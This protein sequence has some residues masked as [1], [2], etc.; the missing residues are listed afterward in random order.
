MSA[1][2]SLVLRAKNATTLAPVVYTSGSNFFSSEPYQVINIHTRDFTRVSP[3]QPITA[4]GKHVI[5]ERDKDHDYFDIDEVEVN[6]AAAT[7]TI[8]TQQYVD[9]AGYLVVN[10]PRYKLTNNQLNSVVVP[11]QWRRIKDLY[12]IQC[13]EEQY[14]RK[15]QNYL[16]DQSVAYLQ[17][18]FANGFRF[19][20]KMELGLNADKEC[21]QFVVGF[22]TRPRFEFDLPELS[23]I[24]NHKGS[25][26]ALVTNQTSIISSVYLIQNNL[27]IN[28]SER[29]FELARMDE[30]PGIYNLIKR[31]ETN[32]DYIA[33]ASTTASITLQSTGTWEA[34]FFIFQPEEF[35]DSTTTDSATDPY[36][37]LYWS[38][39]TPNS[40][41][42]IY[43]LTSASTGY[44]YRRPETFSI[45][46]SSGNVIF[47]EQRV[48]H[49]GEEY[50]ERFFPHA[51]AGPT[52]NISVLT[53]LF[54]EDLTYPNAIMGVY[55]LN[56]NGSRILKLTWPSGSTSS[57]TGRWAVT[58]VYVGPNWIQYHKGTAQQIL[59]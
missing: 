12:G 46:S 40:T 30:P 10:N 20:V 58:S 1:Q 6:V 13:T 37:P 17:A 3:L 55:D 36:D 24:V 44:T 19:R 14:N 42:T 54:T 25:A 9:C 29:E 22:G 45:Q 47:P 41:R 43:T 51:Q 16:A 4:W 39:G 21:M 35:L 56:A 15:K 33:A 48:D 52:G 11:V 27:H 57:T 32:V 34:V 49:N 53:A 23:V 7:G 38:W 31:F 2:S 26:S 50:L 28:P 18:A 59:Q 8:T 5:F